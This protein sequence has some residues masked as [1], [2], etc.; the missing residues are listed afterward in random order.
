MK[1]I[2]WILLLPFWPIVWNWKKIANEDLGEA[3]ELTIN[4]STSTLSPGCHRFI[5]FVG[6]VV[7][8]YALIGWGCY[9]LA[10]KFGLLDWWKNRS[11]QP[12]QVE[13][14]QDTSTK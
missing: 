14:T 2:K 10:Q 1:I 8:I 3:P 9:Y 13:Q 4:G 6:R 5:I 7:I 11:A 12:V